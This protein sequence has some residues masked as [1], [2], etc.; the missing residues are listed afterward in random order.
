MEQPP[1]ETTMWASWAQANP[2]IFETHLMDDLRNGNNVTIL[3]GRPW[4]QGCLSMESC[5]AN[6]PKR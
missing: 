2:Q 4:F 3:V 6:L 1:V 5:L